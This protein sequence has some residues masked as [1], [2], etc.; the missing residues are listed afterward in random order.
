MAA[1]Y[2][3]EETPSCTLCQPYLTD[4]YLED[5]EMEPRDIRDF[6]HS[7]CDHC[8]VEGVHDDLCS[9]CCHLRLPHLLRCIRYAYK[10]FYLGTI[11]EVDT[12]SSA[13][14]FCRLIS[15]SCHMNLQLYP[16]G[17]DLTCPVQI[18]IFGEGEINYAITKDR[19]IRVHSLYSWASNAAP[20][21]VLDRPPE[22]WEL[23]KSDHP[24]PTLGE[25]VDWRTVRSWIDRTSR[26]IEDQDYSG[27]PQNLKVI[28][29]L[30]DR[31]VHAAAEWEY[32]ALS[33]VFGG[34]TTIK[35]PSSRCFERAGLPL[36]IRDALVACDRLGYRY[37]WVDQLCID[38]NK[39]SEIQ[40][41]INQMDC[42]YHHAKCTL[43]A[44]EGED[45]KYG[46]PGV[47]A[48]RSW[49]NSL[50][51]IVGL[52]FSNQ[53]PSLTRNITRSKWWSRGWTLQEGFYSS[54]LLFFTKYGVYNSH[55]SS[56]K[57]NS[58]AMCDYDYPIIW[59]SSYY[60]GIL[61][62]Y[63]K[64][65]LSYQSDTLRAFSA[66]LRATF[67]DHTYY[68]LPLDY[69]DQAIAWAPSLKD[70]APLKS[71]DIFPSWSWASHTGPVKQLDVQA[72][73]AV[74]AI[75]QSK[76][77]VTICRPTA[78]DEKS[79]LQYKWRP[80]SCMDVAT[81]NAL[82]RLTITWLTGCIKSPFPIHHASYPFTDLSLA[83][84][85]LLYSDW[86]DD[87]R[88]KRFYQSQLK[89][90]GKRWSTYSA[91]WHDAFDQWEAGKI[92]SPSDCELAFAVPGRILFHGQ[93]A[94]FYLG[95]PISSDS[96]LS[97]PD[98]WISSRD[99]LFAG[100]I[101]VPKFHPIS[102]N[103]GPAE[104]ILLS[105]GEPCYN[106]IC[107]QLTDEIRHLLHGQH[108]HRPAHIRP[109]SPEFLDKLE[110]SIVLNVMLIGRNPETNVACRLG[111][112]SIFL[113]R[114][115]DAKPE[116]K[117]VILE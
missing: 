79:L 54:E 66:V 44:L 7:H 5:V 59:N 51:E 47:T 52:G 55:F 74:W 115:V 75:P 87:R 35:L 57:I 95:P 100:T 19:V 42:I 81:E 97:V 116:F 36:T 26:S 33:Y 28:D 18:G 23:L 112:G 25:F 58:E 15:S 72:G 17:Y 61:E 107:G 67:G 103:G 9:L 27:K 32:L 48:P 104:F 53:A 86:S 108:P 1:L 111:I 77:A 63:T 21:V 12:R 65:H 34:I 31:V 20:T 60:W 2:P 68:G 38:Q 102:T 10:S 39:A 43:V 92:F 96:N 56:D 16:F 113:K 76:T 85:C 89:V 24:A 45:S 83:P 70:A 6:F 71:R 80:R 78:N 109:E 40:E 62:Q 30:E 90:L 98:L 8:S 84:Q 4:E 29:V 94:S 41:Q 82:H 3:Q 110:N 69:I 117:T 13:C 93:S 106:D 114:W 99:G 49:R 73:L 101:K 50:A 88:A 37:L 105:F 91:Y 14:R 46:L 64:R 22:P 11:Q